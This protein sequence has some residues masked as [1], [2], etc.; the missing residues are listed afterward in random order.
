MITRFPV[1]VMLRNP[2]ELTSGV[3]LF[4][5]QTTVLS[6]LMVYH[7]PKYQ[8]KLVY[9]KKPSSK[10]LLGDNR[11]WLVLRILVSAAAAENKEGV[12]KKV[13]KAR[14]V[15]KLLMLEKPK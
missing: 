13:S 9:V 4:P 12:E 3:F 14:R 7:M 10:I 8:V 2:V 15:V 5:T 1:S 6:L 11:V